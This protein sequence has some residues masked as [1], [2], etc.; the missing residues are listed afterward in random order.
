MPTVAIRDAQAT[1]VTDLVSEIG[2]FSAYFNG[3]PV[4]EFDGYA[5]YLI[6]SKL[7]TENE[8][9]IHSGKGILVIGADRLM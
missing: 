3:K 4:T 9:G 6:R 5:G 7:A 2:L 8:G 1:V